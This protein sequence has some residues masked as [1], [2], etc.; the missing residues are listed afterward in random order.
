MEHYKEEVKAVISELGSDAKHG[1]SS[2]LASRNIDRYGKNQFTPPVKESV[3][4]KIIDNLKVLLIV[5][6]MISGVI[7]IAMGRYYD[8]I[9]I[10]TAVIIATTIAVIMEGRSDKALEILTQQGEDENVRVIRDGIML[11]L[12]KANITVGDIIILE[13]G[14]KVPADGR[15]ITAEKFHV[16]ESLLTG[17]SQA[18]LKHSNVIIEKEE[19]PLADRTNMVYRGTLVVDGRATFIVTAVGD[20]TEMGKI[21]AELRETL[22]G[23]TPLQEKLEELGKN[24][25]VA[26]TALAGVIFLFEIGHMFF[27]GHLSIEGV[28]D[29]FVVSVALIVA[30]VPEGLPTMVAL[31]LAFSMLKMAK[32]QALVRKM[33]ACETIGSVNYICSDKTGTLTQNKMVVTDA[34]F[35]G[36]VVPHD[37]INAVE[38]IHNFCINSTADILDDGS[39]KFIGNPTEGSLLVCATKNGVNYR[40]IRTNANIVQS[41]DFTSYRKMMSTV[42]ANGDS[43]RIYV[44]GSPEKVIPLCKRALHKQE[45][46]S[47]DNIKVDVESKIIDLQTAAKRVIAFAYK[48]INVAPDW[49]DIENVETDFIFIFENQIQ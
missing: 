14:D 1:L 26:G 46:V 49:N 35:G 13:T 7:S 19:I 6:L 31:T 5:I 47:I 30:A 32:Q 42:I 28:K 43:Y 10:F 12:H 23:T 36:E 15:I 18:V 33:I 21:A 39:D 22:Q 8:G 37:K 45:I 27:G 11:Y 16:D 38:M 29:A 3:I 48:D 4:R 44:K 24:I 9:G 34:Y 41:Y 17:E 40:D 25:S 2:L 20:S